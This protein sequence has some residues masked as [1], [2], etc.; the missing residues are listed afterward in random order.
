VRD[1]I[2]SVPVLT[3][4]SRILGTITHILGAHFGTTQNWGLVCSEIIST[5]LP[6]CV[7]ERILALDII[8]LFQSSSE[9]LSSYFVLVVTA[10]YNLRLKGQESLC[11]RHCKISI[12]EL[13]HVCMYRGWAIKSSPCTA[14]FSD[15]LCLS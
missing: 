1:L 12:C 15:L 14:N 4:T 10:A 8:D 7:R 9:Y 3:D 6:P 2:K 13:R 5:F 11:I